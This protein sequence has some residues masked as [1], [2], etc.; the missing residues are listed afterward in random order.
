MIF[1]VFLVVS[2]V[3]GGFVDDLKGIVCLLNLGFNSV[4]EGL[5][6]SIVFGLLT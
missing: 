4:L 6:G 5:F 3:F 2:E 1:G